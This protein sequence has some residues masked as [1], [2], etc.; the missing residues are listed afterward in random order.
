MV[1]TPI[2]ILL[3]EDD[4]IDVMAVRRAVEE[5]RLANP[6][7]VAHDGIEALEYLRGE[8]GRPK[9]VPPFIILLDLNMPRMNGIEFLEALRADEAL[10]ASVVFVLTTSNADEDKRHAYQH[11]VAGYVVKSNAADSLREA[12]RMLNFYWTIVELP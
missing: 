6:L 3:V 10:Q 2:S 7:V 8:N 11:N 9:M 12:L 4:D 5:L 1:G